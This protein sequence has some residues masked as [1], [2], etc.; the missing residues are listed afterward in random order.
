M[1]YLILCCALMGTLAHAQ[2]IEE[3]IV[4]GQPIDKT[5]VDSTLNT[6]TLESV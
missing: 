3:V 4:V 5:V 6:S 1:K 2:T